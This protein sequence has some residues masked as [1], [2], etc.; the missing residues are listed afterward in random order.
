MRLVINFNNNKKAEIVELSNLKELSKPNLTL[1]R[2]GLAFHVPWL[3][4]GVSHIRGD[5]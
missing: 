5:D 3:P 1:S 2:T 4:A